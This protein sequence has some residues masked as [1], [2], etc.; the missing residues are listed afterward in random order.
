MVAAQ[1]I[2]EYLQA[3]RAHD[4]VQAAGRGGQRGET[5]VPNMPSQTHKLMECLP[6]SGARMGANQSPWARQGHVSDGMETGADLWGIQNSSDLT[7]EE[8]DLD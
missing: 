4:H 6:S 5:I 7:P 1:G 3:L 2:G 8:G